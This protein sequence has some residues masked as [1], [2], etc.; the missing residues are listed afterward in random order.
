M[1]RRAWLLPIVAGLSLAACMRVP[2][3]PNVMV[4]PGAGKDFEQFQVDDAVCRRWA[5]QQ[6]GVTTS[7][8]SN[9]AAIGAAAVGT[10]LGAATGAA[11]GAA[12]GNPATGAAVGAGAGLLGGSIVGASNAD[13]ARWTV[14]HRYDMAYMQCMYAKG[15]QIPMARRSQSRSTWQPAPPAHARIAP[16][17]VPPPPPGVPPAPPPGSSR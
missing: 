10:A 15:N 16:E 12:S 8:A 14:Q 4:L 11:I 3:G 13:E 7:R 1:V 6:T 17:S 9:D 2:A 5:A